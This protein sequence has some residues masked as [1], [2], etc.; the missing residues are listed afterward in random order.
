LVYFNFFIP[1][2]IVKY[3]RIYINLYLNINLS[4][5]MS[6][7]YK[8]KQL[9]DVIKCILIP[10][11]Y[12]KNGQGPNYHHWCNCTSTGNGDE[13]IAECFPT[14]HQ[15]IKNYNNPYTKLIPVFKYMPTSCKK[16]KI[17]KEFNNDS[18][19]ITNFFTMMKKYTN[20]NVELNIKNDY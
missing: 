10:N 19:D 12:N 16:L 1:F 15:A 6:E 9:G 8:I 17:I 7:Y 5:E 2:Q 14:K 11:G 18:K 20:Q 3:N 13:I 4:L